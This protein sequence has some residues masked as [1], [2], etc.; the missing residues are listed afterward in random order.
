M[1]HHTNAPTF[2]ATHYDVFISHRGPDVKKS[3]AGHLYHSLN[4]RGLRVFLDQPELE[5]G[6]KIISQIEAAIQVA[7][8]HVAIFS[9]NYA[10]SKWCLDELVLMVESEKSG[11]TIL[12]VF[13]NV[14]PEHLRWT[15]KD[16]DGPYAKAL[17]KHEEKQRN[18]SQT[19]QSWRNALFHAA[20][21]S[22]FELEACK[23]NESELLEKVVKKVLKNV[24]KL[25]HVA[26]YPTGLPIKLEAFQRT[27]LCVEEE[28]MEVRVV[29]IVGV[30]GVG[31]TTLAKEFLNSQRSNY[32]GSSFLFDIRESAVKSSL[33][34]LQSKLIKDLK[35]VDIKIERLEEG[36]ELLQK[37]LS[38]C[39]AL[40]VLDDV[41]HVHQLDAFLPIKRALHPKSLILVTSRDKHVLR[42]ARILE[43]SIYQLKGLNRP[44]SLELF[45]SHA[46][47]QP[48]PPPEFEDLVDGFLNA[49]DGLP[50]ALEVFGTLLCENDKFYWEEQL[51]G[52]HRLPRQIEVTLK[53]SYDSLNQ[54]EQQLFL[55]IACFCIGEDRDKWIRI[56][57]GSGWNGLVGLRNL[58]NKCLVEV[59]SKNKIGMH[60]HLIRDWG[61]TIA[62]ERSMPRRL[63]R[64][65]KDVHDLFE[66]S[67]AVIPEVRGIRMLPQSTLGYSCEELFRSKS[68]KP[69]NKSSSPEV[70]RIKK[71]QL[72]D[73]EGDFV[74]GILTRVHL[75]NLIWLSWNGCSCS[76]LPSWIPMKDLRVLEVAGLGLR[77]LWQCDSQAPLQLGEL[78]IS[79]PL[80]EFPKSIGKLTHLEKIV[81]EYSHLTTLP[82]EFY[83][84]PC[85]KYLKLTSNK[86]QTLSNSLGNLTN[87]HHMDLHFC[88]LKFLPNSFGNLLSLQHI[89][90]SQCG[91]LEMLPNSL[92]NLKSLQ[93]MDF[94]YCGSL[95]TF[96][97]SLGDLSNL[98]YMDLSCCVSLEVLPNSLGMLT[99]LQHMYLS[100]CEGLKALPNSLGNLRNLQH[101]DLFYCESLEVLPNSLGNLENLQLIDLSY[102]RSLEFLP[103]SLGDLTNLQYINLSYCESLKVLPNSLGNL[104]S[105]QCIN[106]CNCLSLNM[107]PNSLGDLTNLQHIYLSSSLS[108]DVLPNSLGNLKNL[109]HIDLSYCGCLKMLPNS[110]GDLSNLQHIDL[111]CCLCLD[112]L[113]NSLGN[114]TNLQ[115]IDLSYCEILEFLPNS[116]G[117]STNLQ[118]IDLSYCKSLKE[119]PNSLG[120]LTNLQHLDLSYC[121]I[122]EFLP[123]SSGDLTNLQNIDLSYCESLKVLPNSLGNLKNLKQINLSNCRNMK[124]LPNSLGDL[125]NLQHINLSCCLCLEVL[126]N[127]LGDITNLRYMDMSYCLCL[128]ALPN[129]LGDLRNLQ[130][131]DMC[132]CES[133]EVLPNS[134]GNLTNLQHIDLSYCRSL[135]VLP[136]S[137]GNLKNLQ[138]IDLSNC[139]SLKMLPNSLGDL[140]NLQYMDLSYSLSLEVLPNSLGDLSNL[141]HINLSYCVSLNILPHSLRNLTNLKH[142]D[143]SYCISLE[144]LPNFFRD[145]TIIHIYPT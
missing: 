51:N 128:E 62:G 102:C 123:N 42:S 90:M 130:Y 68:E 74:E 114:L 59:N 103:N 56:W 53:I 136:N 111:S 22:G 18:D 133:L 9:T 16:K 116:L 8:V 34:S 142:I 58:Q 105:L 124:M 101:M 25:L 67:L 48:H 46:F 94:S 45:C 11:A 13:Y 54:E 71:L 31:K 61:R 115:H 144:V 41:D 112:V 19:I 110:L 131:I 106:L 43:S 109:R 63:W 28:Q 85:L 2:S 23:G 99:K 38:S 135:D 143:L 138:H 52:L 145:L 30:G 129:S 64:S 29:G 92:G 32:E 126:P 137:L 27:V 36:I 87:L 7:S 60:D 21:I 10:E 65:I 20:D 134:L 76:S 50:L 98:E 15:G 40:V 70:F 86:V 57:G 39:Q 96:T 88:S 122:L 97:N 83:R 93:H 132:Y 33:N 120:N 139:I 121:G 1:A 127:S 107:L 37:N 17:R 80:L 89:D 84:L 141:Q 79:A 5:P 14:K 6:G 108:L 104:K 78:N 3:F 119:L 91:S 55:D 12:P 113:P 73:I 72:L 66:E 118:H 140:T 125:T 26:K 81:V 77:R 82:E 49:C 117:D 69:T 95:K 4:S 75:S 100:Y 35:G 24:T 44:H 47:F